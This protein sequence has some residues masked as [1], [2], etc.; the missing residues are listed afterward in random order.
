MTL[1]R[2]DSALVFGFQAFGSALSAATVVY[3][4]RLLGAD[5]FGRYVYY[6]T[7]ASVLPLFIGFGGEHVFLMFASRKRR[8]VPILFGNAVAVRATLTVL[9]ALLIA[10]IVRINMVEHGRAVFFLNLGALFAAFPNPLFLSLYRVQG[11]FIRPLLIASVSPIFFIIYLTVMP[12]TLLSFQTAA[13][14]FMLSQIVTVLIFAIDIT[15]RVRLQVSLRLLKAFAKPGVIFSVSQVFAYAFARL[16][17]LIIQ[18]AFGVNGVGVY[19]AGQKLVTVFTVIPSSLNVVELP[20]F[21]RAAAVRDALF[22]KFRLLRRLLVEFGLLLFGLLIVNGDYIVDTVFTPEYHAAVPILRILTVVGFLTFVECPY[23]MLA[24]AINKIQQRLIAK[25][26]TFVLTALGIATLARLA[27]IEGAALGLVIGQAA[28]VVFLHYLTR[29]HNGGLPA[30][31]ADGRSL[32][33]AMAAGV[34]AI[35]LGRFLPETLFAALVVSTVYVAILLGISVWL[36]PNAARAIWTGL[37]DE[38]WQRLSPQ[39]DT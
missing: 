30:L 4:A 17:I 25:V 36:S 9:T 18:F 33:I 12:S 5:D 11:T 10:V 2:L 38:A 35:S 24:E 21:H 6:L 14:G 7:T 31:L 1:R 26:C 3:L 13:L 23:Y 16:D 28:F 32:P 15:G 8:L 39:N 20:E 22:N 19:A 34:V 37:I 29:T 27:G